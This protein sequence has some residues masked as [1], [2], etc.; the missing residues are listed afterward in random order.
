[1]VRQF[2]YHE[3]KLLKKVDFFNWKKEKFSRET[4][5]LRR[6]HIN[7]NEDYVKYNKLCGLIT[8]LTSKLRQMKQDDNDR[9]KMTQLLL[10]KLYAMGLIET[11]LSLEQ[12]EALTTSSFC[13]R[14][15]SS[16]MVSGK[17]CERMKEA[18]TYIEQGHVRI[19][20]DIVN[21]P[22]FHVTR[23]M[24]DHISWAQGSA[25]KRTVKQFNQEADDYD[26]LCV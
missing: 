1:M 4:K 15:L 8:K 5:I 9:I 3:Q 21:D 12:T 16:Q 18:V 22:A 24:S 6:Y 17:F 13:K 14:R 25:I 10:N 20:P 19:G 2:K 7:D 26:L 23:E 11:I